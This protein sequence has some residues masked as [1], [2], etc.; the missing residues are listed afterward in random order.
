[1]VP[2][3]RFAASSKPNVAYLEWNFSAHLKKQTTLPSL[4]YAGIPY[5]VFGQRVG[6]VSSTIAWSRL[7]MDWSG[8]FIAAIA[9]S[10]SRSPSARFLVARSSAFSS[11]A[12]AFIAARSSAENPLDFSLLAAVLLTDF[13]MSLLVLMDA[14]SIRSFGRRDGSRGGRCSLVGGPSAC[15]CDPYRLRVPQR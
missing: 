13:W 5:H 4:A 3:S 9:A 8:S 7:A 6:A 10:T 15:R 14:S 1:M 11:R 2:L 12:R